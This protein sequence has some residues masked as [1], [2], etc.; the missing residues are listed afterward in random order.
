MADEERTRARQA[1]A[2]GALVEFRYRRLVRYAAGRL[3]N[4]GIPQSAADPEDIVQNALRSVLAV[5]EPIRNMPAYTYACIRNEVKL[6][7]ERHAKGR[8][9]ASLD[10]DVRLLEES[11][12]QPVAGPQLRY[13]LD[14]ARG[15]LPLQQRR[16]MLLT[17]ELGMTQAEAA[18][19][20]GSAQGTVAVH[21]HRAV[22]ALRA[23]LVGLGT[24][25]VASTTWS[26]AFGVRESSRQQGS[27]RRSVPR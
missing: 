11:A 17:W 2:L 16:V 21:A 4:R 6:A 5:T 25:L 26:M 22:R 7:A 24:A 8:G 14:E 20:L 13:M 9:Y 23:A 12:V 1:E 18:R 3:R 15:D 27:S 19:V 10:A